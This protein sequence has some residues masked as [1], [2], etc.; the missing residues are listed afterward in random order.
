VS[1]DEAKAW[2]KIDGTAEDTLLTSAILA[3]TQECESYTGL[4][5]ITR[6][7]TITLSSFKRNII[8]PYGPV[9][10]ITSIVYKDSDDGDQTVDGSDYTLSIQGGVAFIRTLDTWPDTNEVLNNVV[11][12]YVAGYA[13][14]AAVPEVIKLGVKQLLAFHY[15]NRGDT[16]S[17]SDLWM[18]TLDTVKVYWNAEC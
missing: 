12:T 7:R 1:L 15:E 13:D 2:L 6:T 5:F 14:A 9:T 10:A 11:V 16:Q 8:L 18:H 4:S 3:S 17:N